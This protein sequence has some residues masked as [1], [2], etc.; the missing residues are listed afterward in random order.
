MINYYRR[1]ALPPDA[2]PEQIQSEIERIEEPRLRA[3]AAHVLLVPRRREVYDRTYYTLLQIAELRANLGLTDTE[4]WDASM[5][6][7][8]DAKSRA[9]RSLLDQLR[10]QHAADAGDEDD[11]IS[12]TRRIGAWFSERLGDDEA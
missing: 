3:E 12:W 4:H 5:R 1:L 7:D 11:G 2:A 10:D 8:F 6:H 9:D